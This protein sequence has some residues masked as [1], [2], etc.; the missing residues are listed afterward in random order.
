ME[1][2]SNPTNPAV[3]DADLSARWALQRAELQSDVDALVHQ[4]LAGMLKAAE[5]L[6]Q[7]IRDETTQ[8][9]RESRRQ[10]DELRQQIEAAQIELEEVHAGHTAAAQEALDQERESVLAA[11]HEEAQQI[12][13]D[14]QAERDR[15]LSEIRAT[16]GRLRGM[17][18]QIQ[19]M[20]GIGSTTSAAPAP[21]PPAPPAPPVA[22][23]PAAAVTA[24][25]PPAPEILPAAPVVEPIAP[26]EP[27]LAPAF[28]SPV[29]T[30]H[31]I[32]PEAPA[33]PTNFSGLIDTAEDAPAL[34]TE[35]EVAA[36][37]GPGKVQLVFTNVPGY[38]QAA[39]IERATRQLGD[40]SNVDV[41]EFERGRLVLEV[42][43]EHPGSLADQMVQNAPASMSI[44]ERTATAVTF[45]LA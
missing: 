43:S 15:M 30:E 16:E 24:A 10:R 14:A 29:A 28:V 25:P 34:S 18:E 38:Q 1:D 42:Q 36:P 3:T 17:Q 19:A 2:Q 12:I 41:L 45:Q 20:L 21:E 4:V 23:P 11:A 31:P 6:K 33:P 40:V 7:R 13:R 32:E 27:P 8:E 5:D 39:A 9:L 26:P 35:P 37:A 44:A 22:P